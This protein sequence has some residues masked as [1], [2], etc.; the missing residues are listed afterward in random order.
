[1][2]FVYYIFNCYG[3]FFIFSEQ[4]GRVPS[5]TYHYNLKPFTEIKR[6]LNYA[7]EIGS[8]YVIL[9][10]LGNVVCFMPFGFCTSNIVK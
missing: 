8:F 6:Y 3:L 2:D 9:N 5:D 1:M 10:L 4:F 7:K